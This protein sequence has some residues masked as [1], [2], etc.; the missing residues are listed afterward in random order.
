MEALKTL[1]YAS[2]GLAKETETKVKESFDSLVAKGKRVD[3]TPG[4]HV[5]KGLFEAIEENKD[6]LH[7]K[8][9]PH[10]EKV[11][12]LIQKLKKQK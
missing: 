9:I 11:E 3:D 6:L 4:A 7:D 5:V 1:L 10:F 8:L 2:I 12:E